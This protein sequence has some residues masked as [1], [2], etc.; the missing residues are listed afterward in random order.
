MS[1]TMTPCLCSTNHLCKDQGPLLGSPSQTSLPT[2]RPTSR[3]KRKCTTSSRPSWTTTPSPLLRRWLCTLLREA[4]RDPRAL[5]ALAEFPEIRA[6]RDP[7][8]HQAPQVA[9]TKHTRAH[10]QLRSSCHVF[11]VHIRSD[12]F[13]WLGQAMTA[14]VGL[15]ALLVLL[16]SR[17][18]LVLW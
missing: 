11:R 10:T 17:D 13:C 12:V 3:G 6:L 8:V 18:S 14:L 9:H 5:V 1:E 16:D 2:S 4:L 15:A 7:L